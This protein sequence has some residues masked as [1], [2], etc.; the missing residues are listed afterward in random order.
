MNIHFDGMNGP[1]LDS[2]RPGAQIA[3][4]VGG[5]DP[6]SSNLCSGE[7]VAGRRGW[8]E[9]AGAEA[10]GT[11][12]HEFLCLDAAGAAGQRSDHAGG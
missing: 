1:G 6:G 9:L 8:R 10:P 7:L 5:R 12:G 2:N 4:R 3:D 11:G